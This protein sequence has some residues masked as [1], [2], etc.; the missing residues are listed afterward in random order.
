M[1]EE[2]LNIDKLLRTCVILLSHTGE[3]TLSA[4]IIQT[5]FRIVYMDDDENCKKGINKGTK[6]V[7]EFASKKDIKINTFGHYKS[8]LRN[9]IKND[10]SEYRL[11]SSSIAYLCGIA[12]TFNN[13]VQE[14][15]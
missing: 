8:I 9:F 2:N 6:Y 11:G 12:D 15:N 14:F 4:K 3:K 5:A 1:A 7:I 10:A 13:R